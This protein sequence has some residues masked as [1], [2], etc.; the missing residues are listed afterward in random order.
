MAE[1]VSC[2]YPFT[3]I[4][5]G[6]G[7]DCWFCC[8]D[9][10]TGFS[11]TRL[12]NIMQ[13][14]ISDMW[15]GETAR[16]I[17]RAMYR[18]RVEEWCR[19]RGCPILNGGTKIRLEHIESQVR[20][21]L[22]HA[23]TV[24]SMRNDIEELEGFPSN[25]MVSNDWRCNL[26]CVMCST[27]LY[28]S[29]DAPEMF[30][31]QVTDKIF[32]ELTRN[33]AWV[34][35]IFLSGYGDPFA[36]K[37]HLEFMQYTTREYRQ[38]EIELL[39]NGLLLTPSMWE[40]I[41]HNRFFTIRVSVDATTKDTYEKIRR[42]GHWE[43][44]VRNLRFL[45]ELRRS[46]AILSFEINMTVMRDN[47]H[48]VYDFLQFGLDL[49]CD[50]I[51]LQLIHGPLGNQNFIDPIVDWDIVTFLQRFLKSDAAKHPQYYVEFLRHLEDMKPGHS[52]AS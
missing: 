41:R 30:V 28:Y 36:I 18:N 52:K 31:A 21:D 4:N 24:N 25:I 5:I 20:G 14:S 3:T 22:F 6:P 32:D 26:R 7:G 15:N 42:Q 11:K 38:V 40:T 12:G 10:T 44:L 19:L 35:R 45:G 27:T 50:C 39:T 9:W 49:G 17:R 51:G 37:R 13:S 34:K 47:Y 29:E 43:S 1:F 48:E 16:A 33:I 23:S 8:P 2:Y 46:N